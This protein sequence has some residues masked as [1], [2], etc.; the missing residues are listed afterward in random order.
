MKLLTL[1][2]AAR[3]LNVGYTTLKELVA[4]GAL[5]HVLLPGGRRKMLDLDDLTA[6]IERSKSAPV[7]APIE[8]SGINPSPVFPAPSK[9]RRERVKTTTPARQVPYWQRF[10]GGLNG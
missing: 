10:K 4:R 3:E 5:R 2:A 1:K 7:A 9:R 6:L 8:D